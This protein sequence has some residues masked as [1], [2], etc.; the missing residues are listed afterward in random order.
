ML[1]SRK[2][3]NQLKTQDQS[4]RLALF[5]FHTGYVEV[6]VSKN[7][8]VCGKLVKSVTISVKLSIYFKAFVI[9]QDLNASVKSLDFD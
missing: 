7:F 5:W 2:D 3:K 4:E 6:L 9:K 1:S 8:S